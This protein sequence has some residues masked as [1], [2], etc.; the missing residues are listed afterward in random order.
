[1]EVINKIEKYIPLTLSGH[2][3]E[4]SVC[5]SNARKEMANIL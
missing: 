1:M 5:F 2:E 4:S 3:I